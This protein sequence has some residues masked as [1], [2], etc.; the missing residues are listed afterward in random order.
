MTN[1]FSNELK[2]KL[3]KKTIIA[4]I[5]ALGINFI[6]FCAVILL[7]IYNNHLTRLLFTILFG[8][9]TFI[10]L[11]VVYF[12]SKAIKYFKSIRLIIYSEKIGESVNGII[13]KVDTYPI[14]F[15][16]LLYNQYLLKSEIDRVFYVLNGID[17]NNLI[18]KKVKLVLKNNILY[19][20]EVV[21]E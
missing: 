11:L 15:D 21:Y 14:T 9:I 1:V 12:L 18:D 10:Y 16:G 19:A 5:I 13:Q 6:Y 8:L 20:Y 4:N 3:I 7:L 17:I 2:G